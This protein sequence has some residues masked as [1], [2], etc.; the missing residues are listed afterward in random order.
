VDAAVFQGANCM[1]LGLVIRNHRGDFLAAARQ[2]IDKITNPELAEA[3]AFTHAIHFAMQLPYNQEIVASDCLSLINKLRLSTV[4]R[5]HSW[6]I[7]EDIKQTKKAS[8]VVLSFI[9]VSRNS[10]EVA[11]ALAKTADHLYESV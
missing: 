11:H 9:H 8:S 3:I 5:S 2:G 6:I 7:I 4:D 10:N 1:G